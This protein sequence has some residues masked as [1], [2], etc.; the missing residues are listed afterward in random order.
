MVLVEHN[1]TVAGSL[2]RSMPSGIS[3]ENALG[4]VGLLMVTVIP[5]SA[6]TRQAPEALGVD[7]HRGVD[8][9]VVQGRTA[10]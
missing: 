7:S 10:E 2:V 6:N 8:H 1:L 5:I 4:P 9:E 3:L